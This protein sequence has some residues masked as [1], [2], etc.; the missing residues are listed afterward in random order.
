M[1]T[2]E[3]KDTFPG[4]DPGDKSPI[5]IILQG[6]P[7]SGKSTFA[8]QLLEW[9]WAINKCAAVCSTDDYFMVGTGSERFYRWDAS[10]LRE[11]HAANQLRVDNL[12]HNGWDTIV[13]NTNTRR[14]EAK[15]YV[16]S[17][18]KYNANV[19]FV[20]CMGSYAN[21]H[22]VSDEKVQEMLHNQETLTME[23]VLASR[24]PWEH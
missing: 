20:R 15:P 11:Y 24:A 6:V 17:A 8:K 1:F 7:G 14:W 23:T 9:R 16:L 12:L 4:T 13:D 18:V 22:G 10:K 2:D 19:F 3:Q 5:L 21:A